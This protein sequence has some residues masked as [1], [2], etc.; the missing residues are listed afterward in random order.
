MV[1]VWRAD[2]KDILPAVTTNVFCSS[3]IIRNEEPVISKAYVARPQHYQNPLNHTSDT[4]DLII[5]AA[6]IGHH[7]VIVMVPRPADFV[8]SI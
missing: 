3:D 7:I 6:A 1:S 5:T 4:T 8:K 2:I